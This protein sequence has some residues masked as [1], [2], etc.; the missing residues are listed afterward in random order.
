M[1]TTS[2]DPVRVLLVDDEPDVRTSLKGG[3]AFEG[4]AVTTAADGGEALGRLSEDVPDLMILDIGLPH[5]DGLEVCRRV[6][7][8]HLDVPIL[9]LTARDGTEERVTGLDAGADDYLVKPFALEELLARMRA[10]LRRRAGVGSGRLRFAGI[11][12][13]PALREV[14]VDERRVD[15]TRTE[16]DLL[17]LFLQN[18][19]RV[20]SRDT[21][22]REVWGLDFDSGSNT[23]DV[24][25]GCLRRKT[26]SGGGPR[27][28]HNVRG[29]GYVL[30]EPS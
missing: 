25:V 5:I 19:R 12:A 10:L 27:L 9:L 30:K 7:S 15:L 24:F 6:R 4:Y 16:Y 20:L 8:R 18:P 28:I 3:L 13:E 14:T 17:E 21:I 29:V 26:E 2:A 23:L 11:V 22:L 1:T